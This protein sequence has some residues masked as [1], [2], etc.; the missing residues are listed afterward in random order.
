MTPEYLD[1]ILMVAQ[2][3]D[4][5]IED[6]VNMVLAVTSLQRTN[7]KLNRRAQDADVA[8]REAMRALTAKG[9][10][11]KGGNFGR[12]MLAYYSTQLEQEV[13]RLRDTL[14]DLLDEADRQTRADAPGV[15]PDWA[16]DLRVALA[17][18]TASVADHE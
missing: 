2:T 9:W 5:C 3:G 8:L 4:L 18:P 12:A 10:T 1:G 7:R 6:Q 16:T 15:E 14:E 11:W 13:K 17:E